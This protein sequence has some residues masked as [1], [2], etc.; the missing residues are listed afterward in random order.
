VKATV[1]VLEH[2]VGLLTPI[3]SMV[4]IGPAGGGKTYLVNYMARH[5]LFSA[6][7]RFH[8]A[9]E[10]PQ[11]AETLA[12]EAEALHGYGLDGLA[13]AVERI[14]GILNDRI[15]DDVSTYARD[16]PR[17][18][19]LVIDAVRYRDLDGWGPVD[20]LEAEETRELILERLARICSVGRSFGVT[21]VV[22]APL[23]AA[24]PHDIRANTRLVWTGYGR[25]VAGRPDL[26]LPDYSDPVCWGERFR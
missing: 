14:F 23:A 15:R 21:V 19:V 26:R 6:G 13:A 7:A 10:G 12:E 24:A 11:A 17:Q 9:H 3:Q 18:E 20:D 4:V 22:L 8:V 1:P 16:K 5:G 2:F 25:R